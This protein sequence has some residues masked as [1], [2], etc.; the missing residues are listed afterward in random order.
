MCDSHPSCFSFVLEWSAWTDWCA[1]LCFCHPA[2]IYHET[3]SM[4]LP[5]QCLPQGFSSWKRYQPG[6]LKE[7]SGT[8]NRNSAKLCSDFSSSYILSVLLVLCFDLVSEFVVWSRQCWHSRQ[9]GQHCLQQYPIHITVNNGNIVVYWLYLF[10]CLPHTHQ[11]VTTCLCCSFSLQFDVVSFP[12]CWQCVMLPKH[13][14]WQREGE[15]QT[16]WVLSLQQNAVKWLDFPYALPDHLL[17]QWPI[18]ITKSRHL[19]W[20]TSKELT[21]WQ[22]GWHHPLANIGQFFVHRLLVLSLLSKATCHGHG[23]LQWRAFR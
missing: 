14:H 10:F 22:V 17:T 12:L 1:W 19:C 11:I 6:Y 8:F 7:Q 3:P 4:E 18:L 20:L 9:E 5:R 21:V 23:S 2:S 16:S 13:L 15:Q